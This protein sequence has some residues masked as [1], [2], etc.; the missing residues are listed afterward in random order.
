MP[1][2]GTCAA[3]LVG[4]AALAATIVSVE[5]HVEAVP[6]VPPPYVVVAYNDLGMHCSQE[7]FSELCILPPYNTVRA[8]VIIPGI[9]PEILDG[10]VTLTYRVPEHSRSS[11]KTNFWTFAP[12]LFGVNLAPDIGLTGNGLTGS[13]QPVAGEKFFEVTGIPIL[14][15]DDA[16]RLDPYPI[17]VITATGIEGTATTRTVIPVSSEMSCSLCHGDP[18]ESVAHDILSDHDVLHGTNLVDQKPVLCASCHADPALGTPGVPGIPMLSHAM[19]T[20]HAPY[21]ASSGLSNTC[22]ACHPGI[23]TECQRDVHKAA[24]VECISCHG[25]MTDVG[26]P[27]RMPWADQPRCGDCHTKPNF[28][29]EQPGKLFKDSIGHGGVRCVTCHGSPHA[30]GPAIT[31]VDNAQPIAL[32]GYAGPIN[33]CTTCHTQQP[34]E[35]FF[36][37]VEH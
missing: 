3:A 35:A 17:G 31:P 9:E 18:G 16:G 15:T 29:F 8:Q 37:T 5:P 4:L 12:Q 14:S 20:S 36:H 25:G 23:R 13:L 2:A 26:N 34:G 24:G 27:A 1:F 30:I 32:Q 33:N 7:D 19:H 6:A 22:Y 21:A 10:D 11:D 28:E